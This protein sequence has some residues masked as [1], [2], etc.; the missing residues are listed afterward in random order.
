VR[1]WYSLSPHFPELPPQLIH[2]LQRQ[3]HS[4]QPLTLH[5]PP[6]LPYGPLHLQNR[7]GRLFPGLWGRFLAGFL[8][9]AGGIPDL[10]HALFNRIRSDAQELPGLLAEAPL[11]GALFLALPAGA[12]A[13]NPASLK[14]IAKIHKVN[15]RGARKERARLFISRPLQA[16]QA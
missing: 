10:T 12:L 5:G 8:P 11:F 2:L 9:V 15:A 1:V 14:Q 3:L 4:P 13:P 16:L 7:L 6:Y